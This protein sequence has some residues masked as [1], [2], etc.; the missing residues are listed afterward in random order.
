MAGHFP[1]RIHLENEV[2]ENVLMT[3]VVRKVAQGNSRYRN[4]I[5]GCLS[6]CRI[7]LIRWKIEH[8][9]SDFIFPLERYCPGGGIW[10]LLSEAIRLPGFHRARS[11]HP[12]V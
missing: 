5:P 3:T 12:S 4:E 1:T 11:L 6:G 7:G 10:H 9:D 8:C 2:S